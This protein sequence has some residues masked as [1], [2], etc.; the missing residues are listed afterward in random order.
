MTMDDPRTLVYVKIGSKGDPQYLAWERPDGNLDVIWH[1]V[2]SSQF[3]WA[4]A[5]ILLNH[6]LVDEPIVFVSRQF[7]D[8]Q[9]LLVF[10]K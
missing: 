9:P 7:H 2:S 8:V 4:L 3:V 6:V 5:N 1:G 10:H